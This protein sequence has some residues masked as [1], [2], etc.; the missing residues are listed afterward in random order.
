MP[1]KVSVYDLD[2]KELKVIREGASLREA[3]AELEVAK[4]SFENS[5]TADYSVD[6]P[7]MTYGS[8]DSRDK[9]LQAHLYA[10]SEDMDV[11]NLE[12]VVVEYYF[13]EQ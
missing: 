3:L 6:G 12:L 10:T 11:D 5:L 1:Y 7:S 4:D 2:T 9:V 13:K 8:G